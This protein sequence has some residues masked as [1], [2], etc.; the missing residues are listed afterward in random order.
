MVSPA[1]SA[2]PRVVVNSIALPALTA[3]D[4]VRAKLT[5]VGSSSRMGTVMLFVLRPSPYSTFA[6]SVPSGSSMLSFTVPKVE[7]LGPALVL[8]WIQPKEPL[9]VPSP[10]NH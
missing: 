2:R 1:T 5:T 6:V 4:P 3:P 10:C 7:T 8:R 9:S